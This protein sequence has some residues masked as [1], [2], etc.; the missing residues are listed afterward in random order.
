MQTNSTLEPLARI[1]WSADVPS[2][3]EV[4]AAIGEMPDLQLIKIDR[5]F[6]DRNGLQALSFV[7]DLGLRVFDDAKLVEI[8]SKLEEL[9]KVHVAH[10]PWML[11]CMAG[12]LSSRKSEAEKR[13]EIDGLKRFA[14]V[15]LEAG[16]L[17][18]AVTV[19]TSKDEETVGDE[20]NGRSSI[21]QVLYYAELLIPFG[22]T[23][24]VCSPREAEAV[25]AESTFDGLNLNCPSIRMPDSLPDDQARSR[26]PQE[27]HEAGVNRLVVGRPITN[28]V[29]ADN[30]RRIAACLPQAA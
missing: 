14:D 29:P 5:L 13:D 6:C 15:C 30:L 2:T 23:D 28:G 4:A 22:F 21:E 11:N 8:P 18:C 20:Y 19:L 1:I 9:A 3:K 26:T 10:R 16:V 7:R 27:A 25:R 24:M 12:C 17:P